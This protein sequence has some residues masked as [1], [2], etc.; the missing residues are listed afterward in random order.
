MKKQ[1]SFFSDRATSAECSLS[2]LRAG[3]LHLELSNARLFNESSLRTQG[4]IRRGL[5]FRHWSKGLSLLL[6]PGVM[7]PCVRRDD[8]L[9]DRARSPIPR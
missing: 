4:P 9:R 1:S 8:P 7:G 3:L 2:H 5:L 6:K